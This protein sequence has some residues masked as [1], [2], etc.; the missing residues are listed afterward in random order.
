[1]PTR[2]KIISITDS[3]L[4]ILGVV[5]TEIHF[6]NAVSRQL[7]YVASNLQGFYLSEKSLKDL[8]IIHDEFP[9][10][11]LSTMDMKAHSAKNE[12]VENCKCLPRSNAPERPKKI[13]FPP[14]KNNKNKLRSWLIE[15]FSCSAFNTCSHQQL[16]VMTW[17]PMD[18]VFKDDHKPHAVHTP[19]P[20]SRHWKDRV[21][22]EIDRDVRLGII[23]PVPQGTP[24][25]S[26]SRMV[27]M[28]KKDGA[29][30]KPSI[31]ST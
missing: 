6:Q 19:I 17:R 29:P 20:V 4:D 16:K 24:V 26:C 27:V 25:K 14:M 13:P 31:Y 22:M 9:Q 8:N 3:Q 2:H 23:E 7:V 10:T 5:T 21:K 30:Q 18:I 11:L 28:P 15:E 1:M 12:T